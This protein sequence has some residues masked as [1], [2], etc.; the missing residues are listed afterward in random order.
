MCPLSQ[1]QILGRKPP[2][3]DSQLSYL[4]RLKSGAR[5]HLDLLLNA[6]GLFEAISRAAWNRA[7]QRPPYSYVSDRPDPTLKAT[8]ASLDLRVSKSPPAVI[9][10]R[11]A[12]TA[13]R[14]TR[15]PEGKLRQ[16]PVPFKKRTL[17][18]RLR[19]L[20]APAFLTEGPCGLCVHPDQYPRCGGSEMP[21]WMAAARIRSPKTKPS[22][23]G[24]GASTPNIVSPT[25]SAAADK[26][27][28]T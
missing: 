11:D 3:V 4:S 6:N 10:K 8:F 22:N 13:K 1:V 27:A 15:K 5:S 23:A 14:H 2:R 7:P 21:H 25:K 24:H 9:A 16:R 20:Q 26:A 28:V 17:N 18:P 12:T 19:R